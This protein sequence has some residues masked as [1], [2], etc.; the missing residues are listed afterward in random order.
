MP[1]LRRGPGASQGAHATAK[2]EPAGSDNHRRRTGRALCDARTTGIE[3]LPKP[4][5]QRGDRELR[6]LDLEGTE[7][8]DLA[9]R[10][11]GRIP[12]LEELN[13]SHTSVSDAGLASFLNALRRLKLSHTN[14]RGVA[15][16]RLTTL[17]ELDLSGAPVNDESAKQLAQLVN[18][19]KL[20]LSY[21]DLTDAA[22]AGLK[23]LPRLEHLDL[24][25]NDVGDKG[26]AEISSI[27]SLTELN[28]SYGRL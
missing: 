5:D 12:R 11:V 26:L 19:R 28:L 3:S 25:G 7:I 1:D 4:R 2:A 10:F 13:L 8:G 14:V 21:T 9:L 18:L 16:G 17:E 15:L 6:G 22:Y 27:A 20:R 24:A 23:S